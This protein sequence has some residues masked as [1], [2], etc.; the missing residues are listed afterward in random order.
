MSEPQA[1]PTADR[2]WLLEA[3]KGLGCLLIVVH[4]LAFYGPMADV[5]AQAWPRLM[6]WLDAHGRLAVQVFLVCGGYLTANSLAKLGTLSP[7]QCCRLGLKRY[8]RLAL[9]L[10]AALSLTVVVTELLRPIFNHDSLSPPPDLGQALAHVFLLQHVWGMDGLSAGVWYVAVDVQLF[11]SAVLL[12]WL[13]QQVQT[14][15]P[16]LSQRQWLE[17]WWYVLVAASWWWWNRHPGLDDW[18]LYFL[19]AYGLGWLAH[20]SRQGH[21]RTL[22][23]GALL[24]LCAVA[25]HLEPRWQVVTAC[26]VAICL[27][28]APQSCLSGQALTVGP[29]RSMMGWLSQI[30]YSVF[31]VHFAVSLVVNA[32]VS[33]W[34]PADLT[35][36]A[37]GMMASVG[38][39]ILAGAT[40]HAQVERPMATGRRWV[41]WAACFMASAVLAMQL[42]Q[43]L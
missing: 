41:F 22:H 11:M 25:W 33:H 43:M 7:L 37:W 20:A 13:A 3:F 36:N 8:L 19:G 9:P 18:N 15:W 12:T 35:A 34:W 40:L 2:S 4:H 16:A 10:L 5:V 21:R 1:A 29:L 14:R 31:V 39:S 17:W 24:L 27:A 42:K 38:L 23:M 6:A 26:S 32:L 28:A 30:S